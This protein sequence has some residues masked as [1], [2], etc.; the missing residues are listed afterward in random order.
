MLKSEC[1]QIKN[2]QNVFIGFGNVHGLCV[3]RI[4]WNG[5]VGF[6][7]HK[8]LS[9]CTSIAIHELCKYFRWLMKI[10]GPQHVNHSYKISHWKHRHS[11]QSCVISLWIMNFYSHL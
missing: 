4:Q 5:P 3:S 10:S 6:V 7:Y 2:K 1:F 8:H 11:I 9:H